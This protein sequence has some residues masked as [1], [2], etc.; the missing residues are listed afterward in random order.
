M[1]SAA[2]STG[3]D[4]N[5]KN[6]VINIDH[7]YSGIFIK[8][9]DRIYK[10]VTIKFI[11]PSN[12]DSPAKCNAPI[13]KSTLAPGLYI[14]VDNGGYTVHP[15]AGPYEPPVSINILNNKNINENGMIQKLMLFNLGNAISGAPIIIGKNI[16][17][18]PPINIGITT[19][20]IIIIPCKVI[21]EL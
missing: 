13:K 11:L 2:A 5:S 1:V 20:N 7:A 15:V 8:S 16:L 9:L 10:K 21:I 12:D 3:I 19:I 17:P 4:N 14:I 18:K 6:E